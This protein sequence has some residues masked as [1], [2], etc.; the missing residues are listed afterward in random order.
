MWHNGIKSMK[1]QV[2]SLALLSGLVIWRCP[3]LWCWLLMWVVSHIA[4][5]VV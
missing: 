5:A 2:R 4:V 3:D 1:T